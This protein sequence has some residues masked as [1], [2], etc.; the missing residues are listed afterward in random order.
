MSLQN[1]TPTVESN[2]EN[3]IGNEHDSKKKKN[4]DGGWAWMVVFG[5]FMINVVLGKFLSCINLYKG[6]GFA[7]YV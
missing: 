6:L 4:L 1:F 5:S 2:A 7:F 3:Q